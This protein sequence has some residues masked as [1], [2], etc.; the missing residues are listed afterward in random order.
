[1]FP[2]IAALEDEL[3]DG[4]EPLQ[5]LLKRAMPMLSGAGSG[6]LASEICKAIGGYERNDPNRLLQLPPLTDVMYHACRG[7]EYVFSSGGP[8]SV[9]GYFNDEMLDELWE[10]INTALRCAG[11]VK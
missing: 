2:V 8:D 4:V 1:M 11:V 10:N 3:S 9:T 7:S 6:T 5:E